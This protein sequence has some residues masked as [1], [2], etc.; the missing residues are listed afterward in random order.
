[1]KVLWKF[2]LRWFRSFDFFWVFPLG[3]SFSLS[4]FGLKCIKSSPHLA[5]T[6]ALTLKPPPTSTLTLPLTLNKNPLRKWVKQT[7][8]PN[9]KTVPT[10]D[11][12]PLVRDLRPCSRLGLQEWVESAKEWSTKCWWA[13][14]EE[15]TTKMI[16]N[17]CSW[18]NET[19]KIRI[20]TMILQGVPSQ[21]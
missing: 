20:D 11:N 12:I 10:R 19:E 18:Q 17:L 8:S 21:L 16:P 5:L 7:T 13:E 4:K 1:M 9:S 2:F 3:R 15:D 6:L 14:K